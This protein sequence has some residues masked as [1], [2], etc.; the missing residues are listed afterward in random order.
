MPCYRL[1]DTNRHEGVVLSLSPFTVSCDFVIDI[2]LY[3]L[4]KPPPLH[5]LCLCLPRDGVIG[6]EKPIVKFATHFQ[7]CTNRGNSSPGAAKHRKYRRFELFA[8][9][10]RRL[11]ITRSHSVTQINTVCNFVFK[12]IAN[13][14]SYFRNCTCQ[15]LH[16]ISALQPPPSPPPPLPCV[17]LI[18]VPVA[19]IGPVTSTAQRLLPPTR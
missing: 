2:V 16:I 10:L 13:P 17:R 5:T 1:I 18:V 14:N 19:T 3:R 7:S 4:I 6:Y 11:W 9:K 12:Y 8:N 15:C